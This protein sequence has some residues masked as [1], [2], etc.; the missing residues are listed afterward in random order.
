[1]GRDS[2]AGAKRENLV[3][4]AALLGG[5]DLAPLV[6]QDVARRL[7]HAYE[8]QCNENMDEKTEGRLNRRVEK[9]QRFATYLA[10]SHRIHIRHQTDPRGWPI[11]LSRE[12][13]TEDAM[14]GP[15]RVCPY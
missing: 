6:M 8:R 4:L 7:H 5:S 15:L 12:P 14:S 10:T 13:I 11:L 1:M 3:E 9:D 2:K